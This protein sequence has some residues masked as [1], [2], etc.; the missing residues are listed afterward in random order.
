MSARVCGGCGLA[1]GDKYK[2][3]ACKTFKYCSVACYKKH[4]AESCTAAPKST[5]PAGASGAAAGAAA[6]AAAA[7]PA[8]AAPSAA[9]QPP[10]PPAVPKASTER[11]A[12]EDLERLASDPSIL[13]A[14]SSQ[15]LQAILR[16]IDSGGAGGAGGEPTDEQRVA[17]LEKYRSTNSDFEAFVQQVLQIINQENV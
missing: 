15:E 6:V 10:R 16:R 7:T 13:S 11:V 9:A 5:A 2:C 1:G 14:L 8:P 3:A 17:A 4:Q 12:T